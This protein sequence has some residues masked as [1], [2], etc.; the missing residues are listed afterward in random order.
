MYILSS[1]L[2]LEHSIER[3]DWIELNSNPLWKRKQEYTHIISWVEIF[4]LG[5]L[6]QLFA[7][8]ETNKW[9][10]R[11]RSNFERTTIYHAATEY[12]LTRTN[13]FEYKKTPLAPFPLFFFYDNITLSSIKKYCR[14][15]DKTKKSETGN[16]AKKKK[17]M[18]QKVWVNLW[19]ILPHR[20]EYFRCWQLTNNEVSRFTWRGKKNRERPHVEV[21]MGKKVKKKEGKRWK[22][23]F[24]F[25][26][27][28][29]K[30]N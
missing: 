7:Y 24:T 16:K 27:S 15:V 9:M 22:N 10:L 19:M 23:W 20:M 29:H 12:F 11:S 4:L 30:S 8:V 28:L 6:S 3:A 2:L 13:K 21:R 25:A 26:I 1:T 14:F 5:T 17:K 18:K